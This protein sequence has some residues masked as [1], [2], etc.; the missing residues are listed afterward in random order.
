MDFQ[1][2]SQLE[3]EGLSV[4]FF[5]VHRTDIDPLTSSTESVENSV[6]GIVAPH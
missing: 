3:R 4:C 2:C 1:T 5:S 6:I